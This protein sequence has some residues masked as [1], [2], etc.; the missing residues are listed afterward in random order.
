MTNKAPSVRHVAI[1]DLDIL[2]ARFGE[3]GQTSLSVYRDRPVLET[4]ESAGIAALAIRAMMRG[5]VRRNAQ[6]LAFAIESLGGSVSPRVSAPTT[7]GFGATVLSEHIRPAAEL[8]AEVFRQPRFAAESV[9]IERALLLDDARAVA[10]DMVRFPVQL[11]L[12]TAFGDVGYGSPTL[13]TPESLATFSA[14]SVQ[15][16][17]AA[18]L[19]G[20]RTTIVAVGDADPVQLADELARAF[21]SPGGRGGVIPK[22]QLLRS[23]SHRAS[24]PG[25]A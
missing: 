19:A 11:M 2:T 13:G 8:L 16:W 4:R 17:H 10:D 3:T 25:N 14:E 9:E 22:H 15:Q 23:G 7:L 24:A 20:G 5:T 12:G 1:G 6:E 21:E 18:M